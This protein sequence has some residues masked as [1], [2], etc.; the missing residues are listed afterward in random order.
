MQH[1]STNEKI[2]VDSVIDLNSIIP[3]NTDWLIYDGSDTNPPCQPAL[4]FVSFG[5]FKVKY[6]YIFI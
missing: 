3:H 6:I 1:L 5:T 2:R 4:W